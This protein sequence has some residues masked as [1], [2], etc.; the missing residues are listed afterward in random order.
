MRK[1]RLTKSYKSTARQ[2]RQQE[3]IK[4]EAKTFFILSLMGS[5]ALT[6]SALNLL[7]Y[8]RKPEVQY[9]QIVLGAR[10]NLDKRK[11]YW[12]KILSETPNYLPGILEMIKIE[13]AE[14]DTTGASKLL[15]QAKEL[16]PNYPKLKEVESSLAN[17]LP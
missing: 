2:I 16:N 8:Q 7:N 1:K 3:K 5:L 12:Q 15:E 13:R 4:S 6:F 11:D 14:G 9:K 10:D 17:Q